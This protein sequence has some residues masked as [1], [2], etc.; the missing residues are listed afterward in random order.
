MGDAVLFVMSRAIVIVIIIVAI[1]I[2]YEFIN[3]VLLLRGWPP[4]ELQVQGLWTVGTQASQAPPAKV[5][6]FVLF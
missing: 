6:A 1:A 5:D 4:G 3:T 2:M